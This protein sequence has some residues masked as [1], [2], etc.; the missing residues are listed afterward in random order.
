MKLV[1][2]SDTHNQLSKVK[3]PDG[4]TLV[5][6]GD[7]TNRGTVSE[8]TE[9][10]EQLLKLKSKYKDIVMIAGN[11]DWL[12]QTRPDLAREM[13]AHVYYLED[14]EV[15][16][17]GVRFYGSPWQPEFCNWAFNVRRGK[18]I[19]KH[20]DKI[21]EGIDV[22]ITHAPPY[23]YLDVVE[24]DTQRLGCEE[25]LKAVERVKPQIH[26]FGHIHS[27]HGETASEDTH[28]I[29]AAICDEGY[30]PVQKP[31]ELEFIKE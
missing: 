1:F 17:N 3:L 12:F 22:L 16:I 4:D 21:P 26:C 19:K 23:G 24:G 11:H 8:L 28:F 5:I 14:S 29:N 10:S 2:I 27:G 13:F 7:M 25:L 15:T 30:R 20:W 18:E 31:I 9:L 6:S